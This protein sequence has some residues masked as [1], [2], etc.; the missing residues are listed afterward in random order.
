MT[1][2]FVVGRHRK[3]KDNEGV[4]QQ[5]HD[6]LRLAGWSV[7]SRLVTRKST[8]ERAARTGGQG[9]VRR[10][11]CGRWGRRRVRVASALAKT[12]AALGIIPTGMG[13]LLALTSGSRR[14]PRRPPTSSCPAGSGGSTWGGS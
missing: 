14:T 3:G 2:A 4:V 6:A 1:S 7:D 10:R 13:I 12:K 8:L 9:R 11:G 5:V